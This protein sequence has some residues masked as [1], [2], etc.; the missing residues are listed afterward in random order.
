MAGNIFLLL[1]IS[2]PF[3]LPLSRYTSTGPYMQ[4]AKASSSMRLSQSPNQPIERDKNCFHIP[5]RNA[6]IAAERTYGRKRA[7]VMHV[8]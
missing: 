2:S 6:P 1:L 3:S 7:K 8:L 5:I 4:Y